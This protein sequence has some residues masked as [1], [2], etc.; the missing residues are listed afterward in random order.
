MRRNSSKK[1]HYLP[2][3]YLNGFTN[4]KGTFFVYDK[5][6]DNIFLTNPGGAFFENNLNT[7]TF[8]N[9]YSYEFLEDLYTKIENACWGSLD[10]I[11]QSTRD[12]PINALD[13]MHLF[14][15]LCFLYWRL[16]SNIEFVEKLSEK[17]FLDNN[18][19]DYFRLSYK[20][21][22]KI[23][24]EVTE[25]IKHSLPFK[26]S[27]KMIVPFMPFYKDNKDNDWAAKILDD[28]RFFYTG[29]DKSW[30]IVGDNPIIIKGD[31]D[32]DFAN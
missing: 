22:E 15:F 21:G 10:A 11:R 32:R 2:R 13:K 8:P 23:P 4:S 25:I 29:N 24:K 12:V 3:Y 6:K 28:W 31:S 7:E 26:K 5:E 14:V 30:F 19:F 1:H 20:G 27:F 9:G 16:P 18:E 17:A